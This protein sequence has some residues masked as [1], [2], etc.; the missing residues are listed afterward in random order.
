[1]DKVLHISNCFT[2]SKVHK[3]LYSSLDQLGVRQVIYSAFAEKQRIG[4]NRF[5]ALHT[6]FIYAP[7][8]KKIH[9]YLYLWKI[10]RVT[11]SVLRR[12][13]MREI[14]CIHASTLFS[15][16]GVAYLLHL[17]RGRPYVVSVRTTDLK[18]FLTHKP[19]LRYVAYRIIRHAEKVMFITPALRD[20]M[21]E[22]KY[23][24]P[25]RAEIEQKSLVI[26]NGVSE[27]WHEH[28]NPDR[29]AGNH[30]VAY[31]GRFDTNKNVMRLVKAVLDLVPEIP[32]IRLN[33]VG[34][35]GEQQDEV[36]SYCKSD[37][38]HFSYLGKIYDPEQLQ[39]FYRSNAV[40]AMISRAETFGLVY[41]EALS[42]G[43]PV[44]YTKGQGIDGLFPQHIGEAVRPFRQEEITAGLR[45][46]LSETSS[47]ER[48]PA[49]AFNDFRW[50][51]IAGKYKKMYQQ[52][53]D[54][55]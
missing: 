53:T 40:F 44:L 37:P 38:E 19:Y 8:I 41:V 23:F 18:A 15:D 48:L 10:V 1:M 54:R 39:A 11:L 43:L 14:G 4:A 5:E 26:P 13:R 52:I 29:P 25:R 16:G 47:Y 12:V 34:G 2:M 36:L 22:N 7:I 30:S 50:P 3:E 20:S 28:L 31:I 42:Q 46:L 51:V 32:D 33:M 55:V 9:R 24:S 49:T 21:L 17:L 45:R 27:Y 6:E 35:D